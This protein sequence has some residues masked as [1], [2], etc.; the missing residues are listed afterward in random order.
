MA[1]STLDTWTVVRYFGGRDL[2][3]AATAWHDP[4][5]GNP[6][7]FYLFKI[8]FYSDLLGLLLA[9]VVLGALIYWIAERGWELTG[10]V[11]DWSNV[12]GINITELNLAGALNSNFLRGLGAVF[13]LSMAARFFLARYGLLLEEHGSFMVGIDYVDQNIVLPLQW[14]EIAGC[15]ISA[16][17][18]RSPAAGAPR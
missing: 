2:G 18:A 16:G 12:Q 1:L 7:S 15:V 3:G 9:I 8:P 13:L 11:G 14:V 6:L 5:F 10:R 17:S 4:V